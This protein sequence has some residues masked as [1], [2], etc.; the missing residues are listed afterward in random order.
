[1]E[2]DEDPGGVG[3]ADPPGTQW[4]AVR[5]HQ[6]GRL[7]R[8]AEIRGGEGRTVPDALDNAGGARGPPKEAAEHGQESYIFCF[9]SPNQRE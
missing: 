1:M 9:R 4:D 8:E 7:I 5:R 3:T 6:A 2:Q